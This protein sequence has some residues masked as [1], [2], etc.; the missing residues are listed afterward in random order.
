MKSRKLQD[1]IGMID[2]NL[3][4]RAAQTP[5]VRRRLPKWT[6]LVAALLAVVI[7]TGTVLAVLDRPSGGGDGFYFG[8][9][10]ALQKAVYPTR[11][12]YTEKNYEYYEARQA[13]LQAK[14]QYYGNADDLTD[15]F[16]ATVP[17]FLS[18]ANGENRV[19]SPLNVYMALAMLA[20]IC[21]GESRAEILSLLGVDSIE[22]L[23][24]KTHAIWNVAYRD[25]G[26][27]TTIL[28][29]SL[30]LNEGLRYNGDVLEI[31]QNNYYASAFQGKMGSADYN[32][33]L[34]QWLNEQTGGLLSDYV[35][36]ESFSA[37]TVIALLSTL[38]FKA[39]WANGFLESKNETKTFH[40]SNGDVSCTFMNQTLYEH[41]YWGGDFSAVKMGLSYSGNMY[42]ILP[43]QGVDVEALLMNPEALSFMANPSEW[44]QGGQYIVRFSMPKFDVSS[45]MDL[46]DGLKALGVQKCFSDA[47]LSVLSGDGGA[48]ISQ[49]K[50]AAR[51]KVNEL[52]VEGAAFT[53]LSALGGYP[54]KLEKID[55]TL[56][57][58]FLFVIT[59]DDGLPLFVGTVCNP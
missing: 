38:Y 44:Q 23:R 25:D 18:G 1:A 32:R 55:F 52:G 58:P 33:V 30:W 53:F 13:E 31:L 8:G 43:D 39:D 6:L 2:P 36:G 41:Y 45:S 12:K 56:D 10:T 19:Y 3:V 54:P 49:V 57:R 20:E 22:T 5:T 51:V 26:I 28:G 50:H 47:E 17:V 4:A 37:D 48:Y 14:K 7:L 59:G 46:V 15:F 29:N 35:E 11:V 42:F 16:A 24:T 34:H 9:P 40:G 27:V 21:D